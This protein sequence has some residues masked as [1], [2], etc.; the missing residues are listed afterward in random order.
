MNYITINTSDL[1]TFY[2]I[3]IDASI[4]FH[5]DRVRTTD[6]NVSFIVSGGAA[7]V[8]FIT[9]HIPNATTRPY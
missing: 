2:A 6:T 5:A 1:Y 8:E 9:R 3:Q 4:K 7:V